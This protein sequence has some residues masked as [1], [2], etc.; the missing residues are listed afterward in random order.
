MGGRL[1]VQCMAG[2]LVPR[3]PPELGSNPPRGV[4]R[5]DASSASGICTRS[6]RPDCVPRAASLPSSP[7]PPAP[8]AG[9]ELLFHQ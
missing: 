2:G 4:N 8:E 3:N 6:D 5:R 7:G 9:R 1:S